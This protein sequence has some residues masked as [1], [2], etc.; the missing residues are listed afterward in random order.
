METTYW[1]KQKNGGGE[2]SR[3]RNFRKQVE[4]SWAVFHREDLKIPSWKLYISHHRENAGK[5]PLGCVWSCLTPCW[6]LSK[7]D[8]TNKYPLYIYIYKVYMG[9][10]KGPPSQGY[11]HFPMISNFS[12]WE[13]I[14][15]LFRYG[16]CSVLDVAKNVKGPKTLAST[17]IVKIYHG[18]QVLD[19]RYQ[20][21]KKNHHASLC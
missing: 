11:H 18:N 9:L 5:G 13:T 12:I 21:V 1:D 20:D 4:P 16:V 2:I 15:I 19:G 8:I 3:I 17:K 10:I 7:G 14:Q 6:S